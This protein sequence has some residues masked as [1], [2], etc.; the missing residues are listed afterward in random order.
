MC[1]IA[2]REEL[3]DEWGEPGEKTDRGYVI[4]TAWVHLIF[5]KYQIHRSNKDK[6][7]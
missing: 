7:V 5:S 3:A 4:F 1:G 6:L 2:I